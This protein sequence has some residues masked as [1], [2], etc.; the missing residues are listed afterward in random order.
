MASVL[1]QGITDSKIPSRGRD[2]ISSVIPGE[3]ETIP[4]R[5]NVDPSVSQHSGERATLVPAPAEL[6]PVDALE[7]TRDRSAVVLPMAFD[8]A[9]GDRGG[10]ISSLVSPRE[11]AASEP[12]SAAEPIRPVI[13]ARST[14][15]PSGRLQIPEQ[16]SAPHPSNP[17]DA[18]RVE[19]PTE[20]RQPAER[21]AEKRPAALA[22]AERINQEVQESR[23]GS[24]TS[25]SAAMAGSTPRSSG[26]I[27]VPGA[28]TLPGAAA[29]PAP[30]GEGR[31]TRR[32]MPGVA[33]GLETLALQRGGTLTMRLDP[34]SLG[35]LKLEMRM[36]GTRVTVLLTSASESARSLLRGNLGSLRLALED[37]GMAV[38]R[39]A[40][41][42]AARTGEIGSNH[43]SE[44]RGDEQARGGQEA[45]DR[46]DAGEGRSRGR[47]DDASDRQAD[48]EGD[49]QRPEVADFGEAMVEAAASGN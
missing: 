15:D 43:R 3:T 4:P 10:S 19:K 44:H 33:R 14:I 36:D 34:P 29:G 8:A 22:R 28:Q 18:H 25:A 7:S 39:L 26:R 23:T 49:S 48:R 46:Q 11:S 13:D 37:R 2:S 20:D 6:D 38:D 1:M 32:T 16:K 41:E 21:S 17:N 35:Q 12:S 45:A 5:S 31:G 42:S 9:T 47:R 40:V 24:P 30:E 27:T